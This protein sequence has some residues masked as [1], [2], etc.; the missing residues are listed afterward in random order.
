MYSLVQICFKGCV[1][2]E[3]DNLLRNKD[4]F[5]VSGSTWLEA[6]SQ[7][8][9]QGQG[10]ARDNFEPFKRQIASH[11]RATSR[12]AWRLSWNHWTSTW[13]AL[14]CYLTI[15]GRERRRRESEQKDRNHD[16][17]RLRAANITFSER[18]G[19]K[20]QHLP[21]DK[22]RSCRVWCERRLDLWCWLLLVLFWVLV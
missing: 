13:L 20:S 7:V 22:G 16:A 10:W 19:T 15:V 12:D 1:H 17:G 9:R 8:K 18:R 6:P 5:K 14:G 4:A 3:R 11:C 2:T 21:S